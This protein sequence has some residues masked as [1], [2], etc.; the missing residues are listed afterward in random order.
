MSNNHNRTKNVFINSISGI[1]GFILSYLLSFAY[2]TVFIRILGEQY[3]GIQGLFGSILSMLSLAELGL[4][5][6]ITFSLYKPIA[7]NNHEEI[8]ALLNLFKKMYFI[9]ASIVL[10]LG[11]C[12]IPFLSFFIKKKP[13]IDDSLELIFLLYLLN[14]IASYIYVYKLALIR[15][16]QKAYIITIISNVLLIVRDVG[17]IIWL[18]TTHSFVG[19][20][21]VM[22]GITLLTNIFLS[23][24]ANKLYPYLKEKISMA[25]LDHEESKLIKKKI[26]AMA[27]YRFGAYVVDGTDSLIISKMVGIIETGLFSNYQLI[28]T[29][30]KKIAGNVFTALTPSIGNFVYSNNKERVKDTFDQIIFLNFSVSSICTVCLCTLINPFIE[31]FWVGKEYCF[32]TKTVWIFSLNFLF[33]MTHQSML[34]FRN[35]LGLYTYMQAKPIVEAVINIIASLIL[36]HYYGVVGV[37]AGTIVSFICTGFWIEPYVLFRKYFTSGLKKYYIFL[38]EIFLITIISIGMVELSALIYP[39]MGGVTFC[40]RSITSLIIPCCLI[41]FIFRNKPYYHTVKQ[42]VMNFVLKM[43][44]RI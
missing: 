25:V 44:K 4:N 8:K 26:I 10:V 2:R 39:P 27:K 42:N 20:L 3:L 43:G 15:A 29:G 6:A 7:E 16:D 12:C 24:Y 14:S 5:S 31:Y 22:I 38:F 28:F 17:Q 13:V 18:A 19:T 1:G 37:I 41:I 33:V 9:V 40:M 32:D 35:A 36:V 11:L 34:I 30:V 21:V 23:I